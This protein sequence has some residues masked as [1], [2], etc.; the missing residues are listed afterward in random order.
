MAPRS[1]ILHI[2]AVLWEKW[3]NKRLVPPM[4]NPGCTPCKVTRLIRT[5]TIL[6]YLMP[7]IDWF[8]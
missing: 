3:Q 8:E 6:K 2:H 5:L 7:Q 1:D 4:A